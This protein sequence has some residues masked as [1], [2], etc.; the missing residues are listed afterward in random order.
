M[1]SAISPHSF[2][3]MW[4]DKSKIN[5]QSTVLKIS[6]IIVWLNKQNGVIWQVTAK[7]WLPSGIRHNDPLCWCIWV[8]EH[9]HWGPSVVQEWERICAE[10]GAL[11]RDLHILCACIQTY[12]LWLWA[13]SFLQLLIS[14]HFSFWEWGDGKYQSVL[15]WKCFMRLIGDDTWYA[16]RIV[17][18][19]CVPFR[20]NKWNL[21]L[22]WL[23]YSCRQIW[24]SIIWSKNYT[25]LFK[26]FYLP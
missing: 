2:R 24:F 14:T 10:P 21:P 7:P 6:L 11:Q 12:V 18:K 16:E 4:Y 25:Y 9:K 17:V 23:K 26:E 5:V 13:V 15:L 20:W 8:E 1:V 19:S 22:S 3:H